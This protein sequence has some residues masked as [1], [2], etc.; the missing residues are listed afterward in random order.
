MSIQVTIKLMPK[1]KGRTIAAAPMAAKL[2][3]KSMTLY[4]AGLKRIP[5]RVCSIVG[6]KVK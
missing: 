5:A 6:E 4:K 2:E 1:Y 3:A